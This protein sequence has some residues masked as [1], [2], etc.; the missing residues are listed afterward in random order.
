M[1]R[2]VFAAML[3]A[4][5]VTIAGCTS[6]GGQTPTATRVATVSPGAKTPTT[7]VSPIPATPIPGKLPA[8]TGLSLGT[9]SSGIPQLL[10]W[11]P[12]PDSG[13]AFELQWRFGDVAIWQ[14]MGA[15]PADSTGFGGRTGSLAYEGN[16][17]TYCYRV[18][19]VKAGLASVWSDELCKRIGAG[20]AHGQLQWAPPLN[21][22]VLGR[23]GSGVKVTWEAVDASFRD[24]LQFQIRRRSVDDPRYETLATVAGSENH[25]FDPT[26]SAGHCYRIRAGSAEVSSSISPESC[27]ASN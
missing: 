19:A 11:E 14:D 7:A 15:A 5:G 27:L 26:G 22:P 4:T 3:I 9:Y 10:S 25:Y 18:R 17:A 1:S 21:A 20:E 6:A 16:F 23:E 2:V 13:A 8:P 12:Y 24:R